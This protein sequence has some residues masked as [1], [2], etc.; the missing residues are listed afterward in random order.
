MTYHPSLAIIRILRTHNLSTT[1]SEELTSNPSLHT[2]V[3][4]ILFLTKDKFLNL[5]L[6]RI[7]I[8]CHTMKL[9]TIFIYFYFKKN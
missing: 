9:S 3:Y 1:D 2:N 8:L 4:I 6:K 7:N 5:Y